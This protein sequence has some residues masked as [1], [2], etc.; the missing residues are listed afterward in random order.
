MNIEASNIT[1]DIVT[2]EKRVVLLNIF[3]IAIAIKNPM[4]S[5]IDT[6][7]CTNIDSVLL[8]LLLV[9]FIFLHVYYVASS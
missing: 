2:P 1:T 6:F 3:R 8:L 5:A 7:N 9:M 4:A